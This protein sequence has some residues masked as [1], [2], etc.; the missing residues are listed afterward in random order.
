ME[1]IDVIRQ[2]RSIR[3]FKDD[4]VSDELIN[5]LLDAARLAPSGSNM[6]PWRFVVVTSEEAKKKLD[7]VTPY[8][9]ALKAPVLFICC[10]DTTAMETRPVRIKELLESGVFEDIEMDDPNSG[11]YGNNVGKSI[12]IKGYLALNVAIAI[13][14]IVLRAADLGLGTCWIGRVDGK[15]TQDIL[16]LSD[17]VEVITLLPIGYPAQ[18]P[19]QRPRLS[20][21][22]ILIKTI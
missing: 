3:K 8:K 9:F 16:G 22:D 4:P 20:K 21:E 15:K 2:R 18:N 7:V 11:K 5:E 17:S 14:H 13:E 10:A 19:G 6:Q 12:S 1:L